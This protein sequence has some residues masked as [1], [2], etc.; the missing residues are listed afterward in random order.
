MI[1]DSNFLIH[2]ERER[3]RKIK[4]PAS[5]FLLSNAA[6]PLAITPTIAGE[7]ACGDSMKD[8]KIWEAFLGFFPS[9]EIT[10]EASWHYGEIFRY[11]RKKGQMIGQNDLWISATALAHGHS[12]VTKNTS[13]FIRVPNLKVMTF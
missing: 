6:A 5:E 1:L 11:L 8:R 4:G 7:I 9:L 3:R 10:P 2:L 12:I 13:E